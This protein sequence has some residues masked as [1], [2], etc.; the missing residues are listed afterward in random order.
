MGGATMSADAARTSAGRRRGRAGREMVPP[1][2]PRSYYGLPVIATPVWKPQVPWYFFAG[3]MA[4]AAAPL[5]AAARAAGN[6]AL[7]QRAS[8]VALAGAAVSPAL[9]ITDLGRP[10]RFLHMLRVVKPTSPMNV[11]TWVLSAFGATSGLAAG[12]QLLELP[13]KAVGA[14]AAAMAGLLGPVLSTYTAVLI[15][16]TAVPAWHEAR[17]ELPFVFAGSSLASA[18]GACVAL[19]PPQHAATARAMAVAG[20]VTEL[21]ADTLMQRRLEPV[22]R[23]SYEVSPVRALHGAARVCVVGGACAVAALGGRSR[24]AA[25]AGGVALVAGAALQ[26]WAIFKAG[27]ASSRDPDQTVA[28]QRERRGR[29]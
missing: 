18:G 6:V 27:I 8:A 9:L 25:V 28:P 19:T 22:V 7:A 15:A 14:P 5:A 20:A 4:G 23:R 2:Q 17:R 1:A 29:P 12:W 21:A 3:G 11:G 16:N 10:E 26:R 13:P 24:A